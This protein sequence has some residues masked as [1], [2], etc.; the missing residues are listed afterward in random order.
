MVTYMTLQILMTH[1]VFSSLSDLDAKQRP[2]QSLII[3]AHFYVEF[4][5]VFSPDFGWLSSKNSRLSRI[6]IS[7]LFYN[8]I[9]R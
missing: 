2:I 7:T 3:I 1:K 5:S 6:K 8:S 4:G 9:D